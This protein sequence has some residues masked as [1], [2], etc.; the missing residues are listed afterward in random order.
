MNTRLADIEGVVFSPPMGWS[1]ATN[2]FTFD[3]AHKSVRNSVQFDSAFSLGW[4]KYRDGDTG[5]W[6]Y[7]L[8]FIQATQG[9]V[10]YDG[11]YLSKEQYE[12]LFEGQ[13]LQ[14]K[15]TSTDWTMPNLLPDRRIDWYIIAFN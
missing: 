15:T 2:E 9:R 13:S 3:R 14:L 5:G 1:K 8:S 7:L 10:Y 11:E 4:R 12:V 6:D